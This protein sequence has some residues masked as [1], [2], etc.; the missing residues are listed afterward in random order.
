MIDSWNHDVMLHFD[1]RWTSEQAGRE[2][3]VANTLMY[4]LVRSLQP[5]ATVADIKSVDSLRQALSKIDMKDD[6][7]TTLKDLLEQ[8]RIW[9]KEIIEAVSPILI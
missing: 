6:S 7:S 2:D 8:V 9:Y 4:Y 5:T 1:T 3:L